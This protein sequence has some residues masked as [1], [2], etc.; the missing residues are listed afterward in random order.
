MQTFNQALVKLCKD[1]L[2]TQ[3]DVLAAASNPDD[4]ALALRGIESDAAKS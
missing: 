4:V 1:G 3:E 2:A